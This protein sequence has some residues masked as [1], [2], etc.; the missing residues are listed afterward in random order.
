MRRFRRHCLRRFRRFRRLRASASDVIPYNGV[1]AVNANLHDFRTALGGVYADATFGKESGADEL[2]VS[3]EGV[4]SSNVDVSAADT[5]A[6]VATAT[7]S[8]YLGVARMTFELELTAEAVRTV[9]PDDVVAAASRVAAVS[10]AVGYVGS[11]YAVP[12]SEGYT[13]QNAAFTPAGDGLFDSDNTVVAVAV[14][15]PVGESERTLEMAADVVCLTNLPCEP[16]RI[17]LS[18]VLNPVLAPAQ[19]ALEGTYGQAFSH[20]PVLPSGFESGAVLTLS[21]SSAFELQNGNIVPAAAGGPDAGDYEL[22]LEVTHADFLGT[23][24]LTVTASIA[25]VELAEGDYGLAGLTP[26]SAITVAA[27]YTGSVYAVALSASATDGI[28]QLPDDLT[29]D[30]FELVL[31]SDLRTVELR[32][33]AAAEG[34]DVAGTFAL[35]VVRQ[36]GGTPDANYA[37]LAQT[38][39]ATV[40]ALSEV[41]LASASDVI[42]YNDVFTA[43]ANLHDF[44]TGLGGVYADAIFGKESGATELDVSAEGI[45][46][47]NTGITIPDTYTI[48]ATA[49]ASA[50]L[51]VARMTFELELTAEAV[52]TVNPD[53]VVAASSRVVAVSAAVGYVGSVYAV[54]VS[55][56]YTL[57]NAAFTP[58]GDGLFDSDNTVVAVAVG[59]PVGESERT[60]EM[61]A[62]VV[63]LT[64]LPCESLRITLSIVLNPVLAPAQTALEGT[65]GQAFSHSPVLPSGFESGAV[66]ALSGSSAFELQNGNIVPAAAGGPDAGDYELQLEVT[67]A[68]FLGT[69]TLTVT[70]NIARAELAEGDYGLAGLTPES[71][72]TVAA[73]YA[74]S[75]Y[76]VALSASATD[77]VIQLP[78]D[79]TSDEFELALSSDLRTAE[80][81]LTAAAGGKGC[82][83]GVYINS[84]SAV[85]RG[86]GCELCAVGAD[87]VCDGFGAFGGCVGVGFGCDSLQWRLRGE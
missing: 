39:F 21:G 17:T 76:A 37:P 49:T 41:A 85:G 74:G 35:T 78:D 67:H 46:S 45:V 4:V 73:N 62:D 86:G 2:D 71:A 58:A 9:T 63:C 82:C 7:A 72:I 3:A 51:G 18:V 19:T 44:R 16:L 22:Q 75:V 15:V 26:E 47:S 57:Q 38:L 56:G 14:G 28:I 87:I 32:L 24:T 50:Y 1:F 30:E 53:D 10:A 36:S 81:R 11:V 25:R 23:V 64:N 70:A 83:R 29:S 40:S 69:V 66:L 84:G 43:N 60:L 5:Y 31:S 61:A 65:Y 80:L 59:V 34:R 79:V 68:D 42:P 33:T 48:V 54:P 12:V 52:Q 77:G 20:S 8:A 55:E 6:I 13:L 27:N